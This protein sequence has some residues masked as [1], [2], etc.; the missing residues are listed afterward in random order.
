MGI[1]LKVKNNLSIS[2][3]LFLITFSLIFIV[4]IFSMFFQSLFFE[5]FYLDRKVK[6]MTKEVKKFSEFYSYQISNE[7]LLRQA[8]I[9]FE[10]DTNA[11]IAIFSLDGEFKIL[12]DYSKP[13]DDLQTLTAYCKELINDR[14][15]IYKVLSTGVPEATVFENQM[16]STTKIGILSPLSLISKNDSLVVVVS[17]MQ[18]IREASSVI[19]E[20]YRYLFIGFS[21]IALLLSSIYANLIS[22]PLVKINK[23]AK[24]MSS[25]DFT[26]KCEVDSND[27]IGNLAETLN[28]LSSTLE[29]ALD[30]LKQKNKILEEDIEKERKI[31]E[32]RKDFIA[33]VSHDLKTPIGIIEGYAE[34]LKDGIATGEDAKV[35][36]NTIIDE[37]EKMNKLVTNM[38]ELSKLESGSIDLE[39][40]RF[41]I[42]RLIRKLLKSFSL[43][44]SNKNI[45]INLKTDLE[46]S[47]VIGDTFQLENVLTNLLSNSAKYTPEGEDVII[48]VIEKD[49]LVE[50]SIENKGTSIPEEEINNLFTKFYKIDKARTTS[51]NKNSNGL[52]LSIVKR[53]LTLHE[54]DYSLSNTEDGVLFKFTLKKAK[55]KDIEII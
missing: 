32:M 53:I 22:K 19:N 41:N 33:S 24:K 23:A 20:F 45:N 46:Y 2:R 30:D 5:D 29:E 39:I 34:G 40:E 38:L 31:E 12:K 17:S 51:S 26:V 50:I 25:M 15:L 9:Q 3:K 42:L 43:E 36:L 1:D 54:S 6:D 13:N 35:Y 21:F 44:F 47:Y 55:D 37:A 7:E 48:E 49:C 14:E 4:L 28:F 18:P 52:G 11:K 16:S 10:S 8:L 27:E